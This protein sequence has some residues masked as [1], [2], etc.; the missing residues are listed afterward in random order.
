MI[1]MYCVLHETSVN[2]KLLCVSLFFAHAYCTQYNQSY[3]YMHVYKLQ[4]KARY[5]LCSQIIRK[6]V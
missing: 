2:E 6:K 5:T 4:D 3:T 1:K